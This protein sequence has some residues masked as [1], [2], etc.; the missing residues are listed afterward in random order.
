MICIIREIKVLVEFVFNRVV[1]GG[2]EERLRKVRRS[3]Y[4]ICKVKNVWNLD[5]FCVAKRYFR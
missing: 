1:V 2:G 3:W 4:L 5:I